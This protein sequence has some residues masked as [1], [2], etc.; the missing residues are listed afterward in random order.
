M[1]YAMKKEEKIQRLKQLKKESHV[2]KLTIFHI[3]LGGLQNCDFLLEWLKNKYHEFAEVPEKPERKEIP[4][5]DPL[6]IPRKKLFYALYKAITPKLSLKKFSEF[7]NVPYGTVRNWSIDPILIEKIGFLRLEFLI[8]YIEKLEDLHFS[9]ERDISE[10]SD[11]TVDKATKKALQ[12]IREAEYYD[13][14]I[15]EMILRLLIEKLYSSE[16]DKE[17]D[18]RLMIYNFLRMSDD[19]DIFNPPKNEKEKKSLEEYIKNEGRITVK[20]TKLTFSE[21]KQLIEA[22]NTE[23]AL[24]VVDQL[25]DVALFNIKHK[26]DLKVSVLNKGKKGT[27]SLLEDE[28]S[29]KQE[30]TA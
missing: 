1:E 12:H 8:S 22:G 27:G 23:T 13:H 11:E 18:W 19:R 26:T 5:G 25:E 28:S 17:L 15:A 20:F 7:H 16:Q 3:D 30:E 6:P 4:K 14:T 9:P 21:L 10:H 29:K 2:L 24:R